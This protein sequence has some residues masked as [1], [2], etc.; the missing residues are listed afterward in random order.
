MGWRR[1]DAGLLGWGLRHGGPKRGRADMTDPIPG[2][3]GIGA[4][5]FFAAAFIGALLN[6]RNR[7]STPP[8]D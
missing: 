5:I 8:N 6:Y 4:F 2:V 3:L 1:L 7:N